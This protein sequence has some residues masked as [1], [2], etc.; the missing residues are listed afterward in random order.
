[1]TPTWATGTSSSS[2]F[3]FR[4]LRI[5]FYFRLRTGSFRDTILTRKEEGRKSQPKQDQQH[6]ISNTA[7]CVNI[8]TGQQHCASIFLLRIITCLP[9][10]SAWFLWATWRSQLRVFNG[11]AAPERF[12]YHASTYVD[13]YAS[14]ELC[15]FQEDSLLAGKVEGWTLPTWCQ[16]LGTNTPFHTWVLSKPVLQMGL[17]GNIRVLNDDILMRNKAVNSIVASLPP[18]IW[19]PLIE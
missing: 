6:R 14:A 11:L 15:L 9:N 5:Y 16:P 19:G 3:F 18:V 13:T 8:H 1:M 7:L 2:H 10:E 17:K 12:L 4:W